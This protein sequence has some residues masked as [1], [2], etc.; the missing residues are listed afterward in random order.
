MFNISVWINRDD[1][2]QSWTVKAENSYGDEVGAVQIRRLTENKA[3]GF[4]FGFDDP[5][6]DAPN[7]QESKDLLSALVAKIIQ[8]APA[9]NF[10]L[11]QASAIAGSASAEVLES[12]GFEPSARFVNPNT[13]NTLRVYSKTL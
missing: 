8:N 10:G 11:L 9:H 2:R 7:A 4:V 6:S 1:T 13:G 3:I 5:A 12:L